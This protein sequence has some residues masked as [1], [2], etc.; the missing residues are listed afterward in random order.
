MWAW[1]QAAWTP[2]TNVKVL[3]ELLPYLRTGPGN[4][5]DGGLKFDLK[6]FNEDYFSRL[7]SRVMEA[8]RRGIYVSI[9]LFEVL[10][11]LISIFN[12]VA[13]G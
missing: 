6:A 8:G 9:M 2:N 3:F 7:R 5:L 4:A 1:E 12:D 13:P 11:Y 10:L